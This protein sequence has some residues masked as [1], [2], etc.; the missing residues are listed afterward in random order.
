MA[1]FARHSVRCAEEGHAEG[2]KEGS[3][4]RG[5][6]TTMERSE[7]SEG[8]LEERSEDRGR[9]RDAE[10]QIDQIS[11]CHCHP[12]GAGDTETTLLDTE[13]SLLGA[14]DT[15]TSLLGPV[16]G[17]STEAWVDA[18]LDA[19]DSFKKAIFPRRLG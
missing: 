10:D 18:R 2:S 6:G 11:T 1:Q 7:R 17:V 13:T 4:D 12:K 19:R 5:R 9:E 3:E 15:E 16:P 14:G 8:G